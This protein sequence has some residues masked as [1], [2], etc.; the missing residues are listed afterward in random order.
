MVP[1][2]FTTNTDDVFLRSL[3]VAFINALNDR[4][5][6]DVIVSPTETRSYS[7][8]F[9]YSI[10]GDGRFIQDNFINFDNCK[11]DFA[12]GNFDPIPRG[13]VSM[14]SINVAEEALTN[15]FV[16]MEYQKLIDGQMKTFSSRGFAVPLRVSFQVNM[17][18]DIILD[19]FR[20][21]E[22]A[23]AQFFKSV[24][25]SFRYKTFRIPARA[26]FPAPLPGSKN[27]SYEVGGDQRIK[28]DFTVEI[29]TYMP[30]LDLTTEFFK[31]NSMQTFASS[32]EMSRSRNQVESSNPVLSAD[33]S[34]TAG[35]M[36]V[37]FDSYFIPSHFTVGQRF[38]IISD[39]GKEYYLTVSDPVSKSGNT[40]TVPVLDSEDLS[41]AI[42]NDIT[43]YRIDITGSNNPFQT[44]K[45]VAGGESEISDGA[46]CFSIEV[47]GVPET[48]SSLLV[49]NTLNQITQIYISGKD[50]NQNNLSDWFLSA[51]IKED[52]FDKRISLRNMSVGGT[53]T[54]HAKKV[55]YELLPSGEVNYVVLDVERISGNAKFFDQDIVI[56]QYSS[57]DEFN[58]VALEF[59]TNIP[60][61]DFM[62]LNLR[63]F[64]ETDSTKIIRN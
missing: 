34:S 49:A 39:S 6:Y 31:G 36:T 54:F 61:A 53:A 58:D 7:V 17:L 13:V 46:I 21:F 45:Y 4:I 42:F 44:F 28:M 50:F 35:S 9:Y 24:P 32:I 3:V 33:S 41:D 56:V 62:E 57:D 16:R 38:K 37:V 2:N 20:I 43:K 59:W 10:V 14:Q 64:K 40:L 15:N 63:I 52:R 51:Y 11:F 5:K 25:F 12:D 19:Y 29:E 30:V 8:P 60:R 1:F 47:P 55:S 27:F 48:E 18:A 26:M 23:F 22:V